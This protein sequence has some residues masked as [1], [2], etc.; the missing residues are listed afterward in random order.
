MYK[1]GITKTYNIKKIVK[2]RL[3]LNEKVA[4]YIFKRM[5]SNDYENVVL[6]TNTGYM[7]VSLEL[8]KELLKRCNRSAD[9]L[10][11]DI[12]AELDDYPE[13]EGVPFKVSHASPY[14]H[15]WPGDYDEDAYDDWKV[16]KY[17][18]LDF[19]FEDHWQNEPVYLQHPEQFDFTDEEVEMK[20]EELEDTDYYVR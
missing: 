6:L 3:I 20:D 19:L 10:E 15:R 12:F 18:L 16:I 11:K 2:R 9:L 4:E 17:S 13:Y 8:I 5:N 14:D 1:L 7:K